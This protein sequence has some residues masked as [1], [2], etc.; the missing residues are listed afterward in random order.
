M[1]IQLLM[2]QAKKMQ[3]DLAK[4][5]NEFNSKEFKLDNQGIK[6][7]MTGEKKVINIE[8]DKMLIDQDDIETLNDL[9]LISLNKLMENIDAELSESMPKQMPSMPGLF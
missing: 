3:K 2:Q 6:I 7:T 4:K 5:Q 1:N 8:I 9:L